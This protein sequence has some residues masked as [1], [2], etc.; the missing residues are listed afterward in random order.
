VNSLER[1]VIEAAR[2]LV[3]A[4]RRAEV[5]PAG[6]E[7]LKLHRAVQDLDA[8]DLP[9]EIGWH[10]VAEGDEIRSAKNGRFYPV[11]G[12]VALAGQP[13]AW[14][15][16]IQTGTTQSVITRP[17]EKEPMAHVRRGQVGR[18]VDVFVSVLSS[19]ER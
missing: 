15:I 2:A 11:V 7:E 14:R 4:D 1:A 5:P 3:Q 9:Q 19:G 8:A 18:V 13:A 17:S 16:K 12:V 6:T 10:E